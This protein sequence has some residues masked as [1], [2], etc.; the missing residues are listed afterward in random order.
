AS[1]HFATQLGG[2][3]YKEAAL[4]DANSSRVKA[5]EDP[6]RL[7]RLFLNPAGCYGIKGEHSAD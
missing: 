4:G 2:M 7:P 1:K 5:A 6:I 3:R